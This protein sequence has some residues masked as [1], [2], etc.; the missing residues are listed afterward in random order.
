VI[1][2]FRDGAYGG[3]L[4]AIFL[5]L[6]WL[7]MGIVYHAMYFR[8]INPAAIVFAAL[9]VAQAILFLWFGVARDRMSF[10]PLAN[11]AGV[12]G[13]LLLAYALVGYPALSYLIGHRYPE[14]P[15]FGL[16]CP[17][18][19]FTF[20]LLLWAGPRVP[21]SLLIIPVAWSVIGTVGAVQLGMWED[22]G[23]AVAAILTTAIVFVPARESHHPAPRIA[24]PS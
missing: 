8:S 1:V 16:P 6:L 12:T 4:P 5:A 17:S 24:R 20:G 22:Y 11:A 23:L 19:I 7:W 9:F 10:H 18:T 13:A 21:R 3:R 14:T 2:A 15:T